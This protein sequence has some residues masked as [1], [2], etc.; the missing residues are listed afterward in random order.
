M[1][2]QSSRARQQTA[3]NG[4]SIRTDTSTPA[5]LRQVWAYANANLAEFVSFMEDRAEAERWRQTF[6]MY[7]GEV[8]GEASLGWLGLRP[9]A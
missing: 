8:K 6:A 2:R 7:F 5:G 1:R 4:W 3:S 9:G